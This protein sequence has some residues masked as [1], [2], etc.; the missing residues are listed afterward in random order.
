MRM[1]VKGRVSSSLCRRG[2]I[3]AERRWKTKGGENEGN[4]KTYEEHPEL[5]SA[6]S[7]QPCSQSGRVAFC[8]MTAVGPKIARLDRRSTTAALIVI[9]GEW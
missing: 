3:D 2:M 7:A 1:R 9:L 6:L 5:E 8:A 4:G